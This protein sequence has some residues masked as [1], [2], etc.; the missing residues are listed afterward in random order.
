[1]F[2]TRPAVLAT[3]ETAPRAPAAA[4]TKSLFP[5]WPEGALT[6]KR[7]LQPVLDALARKHAGKVVFVKVDV[8]QNAETSEACGISCMPTFQFYK[9]G[10]KV[11]E[12]SGASEDKI[13]GA[14]AQFK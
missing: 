7:E 6:G 13:K 1:M 5:A 12:F 10:V 2:S 9:S 4:A 11:H 8:D 14:I 3:V